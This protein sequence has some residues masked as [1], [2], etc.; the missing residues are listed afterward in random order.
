MQLSLQGL[1]L[2][3]DSYSSRYGCVS[4][5]SCVFRVKFGGSWPSHLMS[6]WNRAKWQTRSEDSGTRIE[7]GW[8]F[9]WVL[10][11]ESLVSKVESRM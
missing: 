1:W 3:W 11:A 10:G 6:S 4:S 8:A 2:T 9:G 7:G 5:G